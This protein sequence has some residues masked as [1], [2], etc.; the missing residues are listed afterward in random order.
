MFGLWGLAEYT[1]HSSRV[2][3]SGS[4][5]IDWAVGSELCHQR[6]SQSNPMVTDTHQYTGDCLLFAWAL[7]TEPPTASGQCP[8]DQPVARSV[9]WWPHRASK[10]C[11]LVARLARRLKIAVGPAG[12]WPMSC[13]GVTLAAE[14]ADCSLR[15]KSRY[16]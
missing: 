2:A 3:V 16:E 7:Q 9:A 10:K 6:Q 1:M 12:Q 11:M 14:T 5:I 15:A 13:P 4:H 8:P